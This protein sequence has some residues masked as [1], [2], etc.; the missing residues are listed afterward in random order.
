MRASDWMGYAIQLAMKARDQGEVPVGAVVVSQDNKL[1]GEGWN[2]VLTCAD[3]TAHAEMIAIQHAAREVGNC[4]LIQST[5]YVTLEPCCMCAGAMVH[6]RIGRVVFG[7]RD[8]NAGAAGSV[9][10]VLKGYPLNHAV[11]IDEGVC[12]STCAALLRDF[13]QMKR[14]KRV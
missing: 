14:G 8:L 13:F 6:A 9:Y 3:P 7:T 10:N 12:Q 11:H 5:L 4:R 2:Q 1:I